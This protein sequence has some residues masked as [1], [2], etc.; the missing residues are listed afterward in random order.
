[1]TRTYRKAGPG[2]RLKVPAHSPS[3]KSKSLRPA[4]PRRSGRSRSPAPPPTST[5]RSASLTPST[6]TK[7]RNDASPDPSTTPLMATTTPPGAPMRDP[8]YAISPARPFSFSPSPSATLKGSSSMFISSKTTAAG[9]A[10]ITRTITWAARVSP[11]P[12]ASKLRPIRCPR[13]FVSYSR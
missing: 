12:P 3:L 5:Y 6:S 2:A 13:K 9:I 4:T 8:I 11:T 7:R 1:M 10:T